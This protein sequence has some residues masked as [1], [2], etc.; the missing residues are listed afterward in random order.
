MNAGL[1]NES[2]LRTEAHRRCHRI[3]REYP[4]DT[5]RDRVSRCECPLLMWARFRPLPDRLG[6]RCE[7]AGPFNF[8]PPALTATSIGR[9]SGSVTVNSTN[10]TGRL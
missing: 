5:S 2:L 8:Y 7:P 6:T 10:W 1:V 4:A 3:R 9:G